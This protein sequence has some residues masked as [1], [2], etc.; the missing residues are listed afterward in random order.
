[1]IYNIFVSCPLKYHLTV[2]SRG[3]YL[4]VIII[5]LVLFG[6]IVAGKCRKRGGY[7]LVH[8][9]QS[10]RDVHQ[11]TTK[12]L[13]ERHSKT[14]LGQSTSHLVLHQMHQ[15]IVQPILVCIHCCCQ[16]HPVVTLLHE[17]AA[18]LQP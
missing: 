15:I 5:L 11:Y 12:F 6:A 3:Y 10:S 8:I 9:Q 7:F 4:I 1:M 16:R 14:H 13:Q 17:S 18:E 2:R